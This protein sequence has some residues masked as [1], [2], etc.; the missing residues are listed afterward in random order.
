M[1]ADE[2]TVE[3]ERWPDRQLALDRIG[4]AV[5]STVWMGIGIHYDPAGRPLIFE[6]RVTGLDTEARHYIWPT[7]SE[8]AAG[9][10]ALCELI[11]ELKRESP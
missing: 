7:E 10:A 3:F 6:S 11:R 4:D 8:A 9:H 2:W 5:V 1:T